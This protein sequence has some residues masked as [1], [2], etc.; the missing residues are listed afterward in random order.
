[1]WRW[2]TPL[3]AAALC[4]ALVPTAASAMDIWVMESFGDMYATNWRGVSGDAYVYRTSSFPV[5]VGSERVSAV[6]VWDDWDSYVEVGWSVDKVTDNQSAIPALYYAYMRPDLGEQVWDWTGHRIYEDQWYNFEISYVGPLGGGF[7]EWHLHPDTVDGG[8]TW[9]FVYFDRG[10]PLS[11]GERYLSNTS[12]QVSFSQLK[13]KDFNVS[14]HY[15]TALLP[16][17][18]DREPHASGPY[19]GH[20]FDLVKRSNYSWYSQMKDPLQ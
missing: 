4:F 20:G 19:P 18:H 1:M 16:Y 8:S 10:A 15:W 2:T 13:F 5:P 14:W 3:V 7:Q 11:S 17:D 9:G 6:Y 12:N